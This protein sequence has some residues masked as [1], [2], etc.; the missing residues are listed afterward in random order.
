MI[1]CCSVLDEKGVKLMVF[2]FY[3]VQ[4]TCICHARMNV[5]LHKDTDAYLAYNYM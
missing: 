3:T 4:K 5:N 2:S 1:E